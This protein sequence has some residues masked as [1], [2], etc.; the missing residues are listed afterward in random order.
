LWRV[1]VGGGILAALPAAV[2]AEVLLFTIGSLAVLD[3]VF[4]VAVV[5][6]ND[7]SNHPWSLSFVLD[8]LPG[9]LRLLALIEALVGFGLLTA[10]ISWVLSI[11]PALS[12]R[13]SLAQ[14]ISL[15]HKAELETGID[16][17]QTSP[18]ALYLSDTLIIRHLYA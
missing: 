9:L 5:T 16:L 3:D 6:G 4:T 15:T 17:T 13:Q 11:Y 7:L 10:A 12:R 18:E 8:P 2:M 14:K 1:G